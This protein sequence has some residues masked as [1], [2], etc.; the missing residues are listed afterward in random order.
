M[1]SAYASPLSADV[2]G[3]TVVE[4]LQSQLN[5]IVV[6]SQRRSENL[7]TDPAERGVRVAARPHFDSQV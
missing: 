2:S 3:V 7:Q 1:L 5:E 4:N 6:T